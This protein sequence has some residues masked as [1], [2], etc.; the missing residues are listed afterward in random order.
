MQQT[1]VR[2]CGPNL[3]QPVLC[4]LHQELH[5]RGVSLVHVLFEFITDLL[6][7]DT[8]LV[9]E[10]QMILQVSQRPAVEEKDRL[11]VGL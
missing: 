5:L 11:L 7:L 9:A 10:V 3:L 8:K 6:C 1:S 4:P 2:L